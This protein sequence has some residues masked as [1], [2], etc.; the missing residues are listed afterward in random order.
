M[1]LNGNLSL[2]FRCVFLFCIISYQVLRRMNSSDLDVFYIQALAGVGK[3][4]LLLFLVAQLLRLEPRKPDDL[5]LV[6]LP[7]RELRDDMCMTWQRTAAALGLPAACMIWLGRQS[8]SQRSKS[9][10]KDCT[11]RHCRLQGSSVTSVSA[12]IA[13][14][15]L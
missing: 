14:M 4:T 15:P 5:L 2:V 13:C 3:T 7:S 10:W 9:S 11:R 1:L 6:C 8:D 12:R